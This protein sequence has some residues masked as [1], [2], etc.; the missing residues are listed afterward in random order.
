MLLIG[1]RWISHVSLGPVYITDALLVL[2]VV[3]ALGRRVH[4]G[5]SAEDTRGP[6]ILVGLVLLVVLARFVDI[7]GDVRTAARDAAPFAYAAI[8]YLSASTCQQ[9]GEA[10]RKRTI[11]VLH[12]ALVI[13]LGCVALAMF[14]PEVVRS[15]PEVENGVHP[16]QIRTDF[17][18]AMLGVLVGLSILRIR[19]GCFWFNTSLVA[20]ALVV[21]FN[22]QSRAGLLSFCACV[23]T[24][25]MIRLDNRRRNVARTV[26]IGTTTVLV[27]AVVLPA[28]PAGQRLLATTGSAGASQPM[29]LGVQG[30]TQARMIAWERVATFTLDDPVRA[31]LG[32]GFGTDFLR[33]SD[34]DLPLGGRTIGLRSPHNYLLT[35]FARLGFVGLTAIAALLMTLIAV[36]IRTV[37]SVVPDELEALSM[38][39]VI[40]ILIAAM[41]GVVLESPFGAL[42]FFWAAGILLGN[43]RLRR[44]KRREK[45]ESHSSRLPA[46]A[47]NMAPSL[48][49]CVHSSSSSRV[50]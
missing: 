38:L 28:T 45:A 2:A 20:A 15:L 1:G 27:L 7:Q 35:T 33:L 32:V 31:T 30:T 48:T 46:Q 37:W 6:G 16:L 36:V 17:D 42:P 39:L 23:V 43:S 29:A 10:G 9:T 34:G 22:L 47:A 3:Q 26:L 19:R 13:H 49:G 44:K 50:R 11:Q 24:A 25:C 14:A 4:S 40:A 41:V 8:A 18:S 12:G 21:S 5:K